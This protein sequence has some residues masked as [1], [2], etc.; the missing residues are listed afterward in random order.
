MECGEG[1]AG[2]GQ[3]S[4]GTLRGGDALLVFFKRMSGKECAVWRSKGFA[5]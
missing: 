5:V 1:K 2:Q 3:S 4:G